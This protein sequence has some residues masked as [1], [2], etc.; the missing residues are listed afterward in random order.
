MQSS[1]L[2]GIKWDLGCFKASIVWHQLL[3]MLRICTFLIYVG[4][5]ICRFIIHKE[6]VPDTH[7]IRDVLHHA[8][9]KQ[10]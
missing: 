5:Q 9:L 10:R 3:S 8:S 1:N 6:Y 2:L 4:L 7:A